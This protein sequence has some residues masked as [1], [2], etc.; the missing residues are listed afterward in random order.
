MDKIIMGIIYM[1][2][3][4]FHRLGD[5]EELFQEA[6]AAI[7][8]SL[9]KRQFD[10]AKGTVFNF[11]S[12]VCSKNLMNYTCKLNKHMG[13]KSNADISILYNNDSITYHHDMEQ[14]M[15]FENVISILK[16][17]FIKK[18]NFQALTN[19]LTDYYNVN[20]GNR[21]IK[22]HFILYAKGHGFSPAMV[23]TFFNYCKRI[24]RH[25]E[26]KEI[27]EILERE[28]HDNIRRF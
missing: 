1:P 25:T 28:H 2:K 5:V 17:Y 9:H 3:P 7:I 6:R 27:L 23:N 26:M 24:A 8:S 14:E 4:G 16:K 22:K 19:L 13:K 11:F 12:T 21:F 20:N 15:L 10:P 18:P